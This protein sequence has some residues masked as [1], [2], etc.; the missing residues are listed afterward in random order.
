MAHIARVEKERHHY[1]EVLNNARLECKSLYTVNGI[2]TPPIQRPQ[3]QLSINVHYS[4]D[5]A[6]QVNAKKIIILALL[7]VY[8][9]SYCTCTIHVQ[10]MQSIHLQFIQGQ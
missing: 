2:Y 10:T 7:P 4:F 9:N 1:R 8:M 6:Q 5:F 3:I